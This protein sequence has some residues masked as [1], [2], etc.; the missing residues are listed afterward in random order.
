MIFVFISSC[1]KR[2]IFDL[3][4]G[5]LAESGV[6]SDIYNKLF[7]IACEDTVFKLEN[8]F[9]LNMKPIL[10]REDVVYELPVPQITG[11]LRRSFLRFL[12]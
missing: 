4:F 2:N 9:K 5:S 1:T 8:V 11:S 3:P 12:T 10:A 7:E 6:I